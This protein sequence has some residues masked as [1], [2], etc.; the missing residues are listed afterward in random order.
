M[1]RHRRI[2]L[3]GL[4]VE[5]ACRLK[6]ERGIARLPFH[7]SLEGQMA[8]VILLMQR[9]T[10]AKRRLFDREALQKVFGVSMEVEGM[11][12]PRDLLRRCDRGCRAVFRR[13]GRQWAGLQ[14][15]IPMFS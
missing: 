5:K 14:K 9:G 3:R 15:A 7:W 11:R 12:R 2:A 8:R 4:D 13:S 10:L 1:G 6:R